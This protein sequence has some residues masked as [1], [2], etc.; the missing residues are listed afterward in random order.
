MKASR[1]TLRHSSL[2]VIALVALVL[3]GCVVV[4]HTTSTYNPDCQLVSEHMELQP[5]QIAGMQSCQG[6][7]C[8]AA[9]AYYGAVAAASVVVSGSI[10]VVGNAVYWV[11]EHGRCTSPP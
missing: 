2:W 1:M 7:G 11:E 10:V 8:A 6:N 4:P 5:I 3:Q 9:L